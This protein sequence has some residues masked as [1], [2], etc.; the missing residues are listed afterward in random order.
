M[1][2]QFSTLFTRL[3]Q[4]S[5]QKTKNSI[6]TIKT[7]QFT[8]VNNPNPQ[9]QTSKIPP[10]HLNSSPTINFHN[11]TTSHTTPTP[12]HLTHRRI[13]TNNSHGYHTRSSFHQTQPLALFQQGLGKAGQSRSRL[14]AVSKPEPAKVPDPLGIEAKQKR[15][16]AQLNSMKEGK[17]FDQFSGLTQEQRQKQVEYLTRMKSM[18]E[19]LGW[20][21]FILS[22]SSTYYF[23]WF[24]LIFSTMGLGWFGISTYLDWDKEM[25]ILESNPGLKAAKAG[26]PIPGSQFDNQHRLK[27]L[28]TADEIANSITKFQNPNFVQEIEHQTHG[29][30]EGAYPPGSAPYPPSNPWESRK[31][32]IHAFITSGL[33]YPDYVGDGHFH[34]YH[35]NKDSIPSILEKIQK[36]NFGMPFTF[37]IL[38]FVEAHQMF[39]KPLY[40]PRTIEELDQDRLTGNDS[41][42]NCETGMV[43]GVLREEKE[44]LDL[45]KKKGLVLTAP[46]T[47]KQREEEYRKEQDRLLKQQHELQKKQHQTGQV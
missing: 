31:P 35:N 36:D 28:A 47:Y 44:K 4:H 38:S 11:P 8:T 14:G 41:S 34:I 5:S 3:L 45:E 24:T 1:S 2:S 23:V 30:V 29:F 7:R 18:E 17:E 15:L 10:T 25:T 22:Q 13:F 33:S 43:L 27:L 21:E 46:K 42:L 12:H 26:K 6:N 16:E 9:I 20:V 19:T 37:Q 40:K 39:T 32:I